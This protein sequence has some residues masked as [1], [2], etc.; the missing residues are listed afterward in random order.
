M[1]IIIMLYCDFKELF[2]RKWFFKEK[3][4]KITKNWEK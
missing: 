1:L 2:L 3:C 4:L